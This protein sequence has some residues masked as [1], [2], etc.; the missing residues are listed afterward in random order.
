MNWPEMTT[1]LFPNYFTST[2]RNL[3]KKSRVTCYRISQ[4]SHVD[5]AYLWRLMK[6]D[7]NNPSPETVVKI[8][9]ALAHLSDNTTIYD[10]NDLFKAIGHPLLTEY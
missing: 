10:I 6:G 3:V 5:E 8:S 9:L 1:T 7:K 4:Y 2:F